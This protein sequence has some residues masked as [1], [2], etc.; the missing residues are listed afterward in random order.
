MQVITTLFSG[1]SVFRELFSGGSV[2]RERTSKQPVQAKQAKQAKTQTPATPRSSLANRP[3]NPFRDE[4]FFCHLLFFIRK[5]VRPSNA[6]FVIA[7]IHHQPITCHLRHRC[8][9]SSTP[10]EPHLDAHV[11]F[12]FVWLC[13]VCFGTHVAIGLAPINNG[14][15]GSWHE[16]LSTLPLYADPERKKSKAAIS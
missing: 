8:H 10:L 16:K 13:V 7:A 15:R 9:P 5:R 6:I 2:F 14:S 12:F 1:C 4:I 3:T 11:R